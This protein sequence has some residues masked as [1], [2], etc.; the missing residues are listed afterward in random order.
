MDQS[1]MDTEEH[2]YLS[3]L[4]S[5]FSPI[6]AKDLAMVYKVLLLLPL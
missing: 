4:V 1:S 3:A 2:E 5:H 6:K